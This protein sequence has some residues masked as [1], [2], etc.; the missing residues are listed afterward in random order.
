MLSLL[1]YLR[2]RLDSEIVRG[3]ESLRTVIYL[4]CVGTADLSGRANFKWPLA[5]YYISV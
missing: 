2:A 1:G 5:M 3:A 4:W